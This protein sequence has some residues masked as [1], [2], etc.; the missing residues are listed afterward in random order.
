MTIWVG[1]NDIQKADWFYK[2]DDDAYFFPGF[3]RKFVADRNWNPDDHHYFGHRLHHEVTAR[4]AA[5]LPHAHAHATHSPR[6]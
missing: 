6:S 1:T 2:V 4:C 5:C 3:A